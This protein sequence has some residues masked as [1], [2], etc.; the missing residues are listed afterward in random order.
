MA[1]ED[2]NLVGWTKIAFPRTWLLNMKQFFHRVFFIS[3]SLASSVN[4]F[5]VDR[6]KSF[7]A[8]KW[9]FPLQQL[10]QLI[11]WKKAQAV[12]PWLL[13][14]HASPRVLKI[15]ITSRMTEMKFLHPMHERI[16]KLSTKQQPRATLYYRTELPNP[17]NTTCFGSSKKILVLGLQ[18]I[19]ILNNPFALK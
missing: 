3:S 13:I 19:N 10:Q 6:W 9:N 18:A 1:T 15:P 17:S 14:G 2:L 16:V 5:D 8:V 4:N 12:A 11:T 7:D